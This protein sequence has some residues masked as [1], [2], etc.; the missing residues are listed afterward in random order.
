M[1]IGFLIVTHQKPEQLLFLLEQLLSLSK[2]NLIFI[3]INK[4]YEEINKSYFE[5]NKNS[6]LS[7]ERVIFLKDTY[8]IDW[9]K[10]GLLLAQMSLLEEARKRNLDY[11]IYLSG[12]DM[13]IKKGLQEFVT[14]NSNKTFIEYSELPE[15]GLFKYRRMYSKNNELLIP[16]KVKMEYYWPP[17]LIN[18]FGTKIS[19][20]RIR[21]RLRIE[22]YK[23]GF[24]GKK[25]K[26]SY[27]PS[28]YWYSYFWISFPDNVAAILLN[29][30]NDVEHRRLWLGSLVPEENF[31]ATV[32]MNSLEINKNDI[33]NHDLVFLNKIEGSNH[34]KTNTLDDIPQIDACDKE[35]FFSRKFDVNVDK[36]VVEYYLKLLSK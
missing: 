15:C 6:S 13:M 7:D 11:Y 31:F 1:K 35:K 10:D 29:E 19:L 22:L 4:K 27:K 14:T 32:I 26:I 17:K 2:D 30:W 21:R 24:P 3:H 12:Q 34:V 16:G 36:S 28:K 5:N 8:A 18:E 25:K 33:A 23:R 9:G 20:N